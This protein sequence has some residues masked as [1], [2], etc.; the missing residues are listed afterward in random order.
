MYIDRPSTRLCSL[1]ILE[2]SVSHNSRKLGLNILEKF[3]LTPDI[4][5]I[6]QKFLHR[7]IDAMTLY[8]LPLPFDQIW[9]PPGR[10]G[11]QLNF[12]KI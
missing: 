7:W 4:T 5:D 6:E 8:R 12:Y 2:N 11:P 9:L 1:K 3:D 10:E